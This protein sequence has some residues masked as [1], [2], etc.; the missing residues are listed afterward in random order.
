VT[1][2]AFLAFALLVVLQRPGEVPVPPGHR[3][4]GPALRSEVIPGWEIFAADLPPLT[5]CTEINEMVYALNP[6]HRD[7]AI[8]M[9][10]RTPFRRISD[11]RAAQF[12]GMTVRGREA[13]ATTVFQRLIDALRERKRRQLEEQ[14]G[15]W[16]VADQRQLDQLT[17]S[18]AAGAHRGYRPYL[19]RGVSKFGDGHGGRPTMFGSLCG[20]TLRLH[21]LTFSY[22]IPPTVRVPAVVF[23][24]AAP[25]RV[26]ATVQVAW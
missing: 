7:E 4:F 8:R 2:S 23:L 6:P 5:G 9:L 24:P 10:E 15:S 22:T 16:S 17:A 19:V 26:L 18:F 20:R 12:L 3:P 11:R 25:E 21:T 13:L 14:Q 1:P